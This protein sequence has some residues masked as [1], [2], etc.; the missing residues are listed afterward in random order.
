MTTKPIKNS[1][2]KVC[3]IG[4][5]IAGLCAAY[6]LGKSGFEVV[7]V[8]SN[9]IPGGLARYK[10]VNGYPVD[11]FYHFICRGDV[12]LQS[13]IDEIGIADKLRWREAKTSFYYQG[14]MY[15]F[16][17]PTDLMRFSPVPFIQRLRFGYN[18]VRSRYAK[19]WKDLD[20]LS[21]CS[22]LAK[23]IG[24][25][26]YQVIW[27]P[28]LRFKFGD[29]YDQISAA[30]IWHRIH[31]VAKSRRRMW[32]HER[33]GYL[34]GGSATLIDAISASLEAM[35]NVSMRTATR[36]L[37]VKSNG[38]DCF[39]IRLTDAPDAITSDYVLSTIALPGVL[40]ICKEF[41][42]SYQQA[43]EKVE[44]LGVV[45]GLLKL[46]H[47][48]TDSFWINIAD[49]N[50][51]FNGII[52]YSNLN[53]EMEAGKKS[54]IYIPYYLRTSLPRFN[55]S[56]E[57]LMH[58]FV[59]GLKKINPRFQADWIED[60]LISRAT[61]A[62]AICTIGFSN[63]IPSINTPLKGFYL[64]DSTQFYPEDRTVSAAIRQGRYAAKM[65]SSG[66]YS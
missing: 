26:G 44:Y 27:E 63:V 53:Q 61:Y 19:D 2:K 60:C 4:A 35:P 20:Q 23:E 1:T 33:Y 15:D 58:D 12:E 57:E 8:E 56:S 52:E 25:K 40:Q 18:I 3:I 46:N 62:Q 55:Q 31:R 41:P 39:S 43:L 50:I 48:L 65:I 30:W 34:L 9:D 7:L 22:W 10:Q 38:N 32:E 28:L 36:A 51:P 54:I 47:R 42:E 16:G 11:I 14:K 66:L 49:E 5:G 64:T 29:A 45:C 59:S 17:L 13:F 6:D 24:V 21:A 37:E